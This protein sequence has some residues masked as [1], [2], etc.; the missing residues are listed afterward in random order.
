VSVEIPLIAVAA[1][2]VD[3]RINSDAVAVCQF[4]AVLLNQSRA[5]R[6]I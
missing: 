1:W 6:G 4:S 2:L 3:I 5:L